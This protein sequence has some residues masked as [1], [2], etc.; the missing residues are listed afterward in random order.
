MSPI[1]GRAK[2]LQISAL[3]RH[4]LVHPKG[5]MSLCPSG[6]TKFSSGPWTTLLTCALA[7]LTMGPHAKLAL[8]TTITTDLCYSPLDHGAACQ[9]GS[10]DLLEC[11]LWVADVLGQHLL[12]DVI[13]AMTRHGN[14]R[15]GSYTRR[16]MLLEN[17]KKT[18]GMFLNSAVSS[19]S[20]HS[21]RSTLH[22]L[23]DLFIPIPNRQLRE[24]FSHAAIAAITARILFPPLCI[25]RYS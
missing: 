5:H 19:P 23:A 1:L 25:A 6:G 2:N 14:M 15:T 4:L 13:A 17:S 12:T 7:H 9:A 10:V 20:Y 18:K 22:P 21:N 24:A 11:V 3:P 16:N 8:L